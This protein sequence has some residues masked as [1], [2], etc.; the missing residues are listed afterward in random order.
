MAKPAAASATASAEEAAAAAK[1]HG[2]LYSLSI[3]V[4][5]NAHTIF[6]VAPFDSFAVVSDLAE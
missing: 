6:S 1:L 2:T 5:Q 3:T 4:T